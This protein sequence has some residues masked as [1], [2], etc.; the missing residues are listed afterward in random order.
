[1]LHPTR[2]GLA[3]TSTDAAS[4][5]PCFWKE[6]GFSQWWSYPPIPS[7]LQGKCSPHFQ[8]VAEEGPSTGMGLFCTGE[9]YE[10][11]LG[12]ETFVTA[13]LCL[14]KLWNLSSIWVSPTV[15]FLYL[16][17]RSTVLNLSSTSEMKIS[18]WVLIKY[19]EQAKVHLQQL[20]S[21]YHH[22]CALFLC[23]FCVFKCLFS[24]LEAGT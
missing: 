10:L 13:L 18:N 15:K 16:P 17:A 9:R 2:E 23:A 7:V 1:M 3:P 24:L 11:L 6:T 19:E 21:F 20:S 14:G 5:V 22:I 12:W 4:D 8:H